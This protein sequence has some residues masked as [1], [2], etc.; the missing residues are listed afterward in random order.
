MTGRTPRTP[1]RPARTGSRES[2]P[3][4]SPRRTYASA[5]TAFDGRSDYGAFI[6]AGIPAGGLFSGAEGIKTEEEAEEYGGVAKA[7]Y[8]E[9]YHQACD[10]V[11]NLNAR[12]LKELGD[13]AAHATL[14]LATS[15][16]GIYPDGSRVAAK[17]AKQAA[18]RLPYKGSKA[19]F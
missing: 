3:T 7:P 10:T 16:S 8:D 5:P 17:R 2:S 11:T 4:T 18:V 19:V 14:V 12:A 13:A 6:E 1:V 15:K 9:C